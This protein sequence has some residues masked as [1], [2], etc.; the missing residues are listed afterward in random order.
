MKSSIEDIKATYIAINVVKELVDTVD[1]SLFITII[2]HANV[3]SYIIKTSH[4]QYHNHFH[5]YMVI[6]YERRSKGPHIT[7][8]NF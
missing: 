5:T 8:S 1:K 7:Q 2:E 4:M 6:R 3:L